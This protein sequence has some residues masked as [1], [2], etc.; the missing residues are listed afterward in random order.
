MTTQ[1]RCC[2]FGGIFPRAP[3][4]ASSLQDLLAPCLSLL[5]AASYYWLCSSLILLV[6]LQEG[7]PGLHITV[8]F[9]STYSA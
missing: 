7:K 3:G 9:P 5:P 8:L 4:S 6:V 2:R 1:V